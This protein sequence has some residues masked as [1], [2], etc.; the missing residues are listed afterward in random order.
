MAVYTDISDDDLTA[1]V[2][3]Y[4]IGEVLS[5]KGIA[6]GVENSN[7]LLVT[8]QG[9]FILTLYEK[10][11]DANDLPFFLGLTE[12]LSARG[13][14]CP[15]PVHAL[16]GEVLR[17][18]SGRP[19]AIVTFLTGMWPKRIQNHHCA[20]LGRAM[21]E[22]HVTG[23]D[24]ELSRP[25]ALSVESWRPLL[26][27]C[28]GRGDDVLP[29]ITAALN[30]ELDVL[31]SEWPRDLPSGVIH[32][33]LFPDNVFFR[34]E[35]LSG[36]IDFYFACN[37]Q[38]AYDLGICLN[39]WCF[40]RDGSFNATKARKMLRAYRK[41][42]ELSDAEVQA[43]PLLARGAAMRFLLTR[44][45][46]W[47]NTPENALVT[48]KNPLEYYDKLRFHQAVTGPGAYGLD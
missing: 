13:I 30:A 4:G 1:F 8:E 10:R 16:N 31:E 34:G 7:F 47:L 48:P 11:V 33:D 42:R 44:L 22:M 35:H 26:E 27:A 45:Y 15:T 40:E 37:D 12:H 19:A 39:A 25:N 28:E 18:L 6:E 9:S 46:D 5:C 2:A 32:A 24:F 36:L 41:V 43:L 20:E 23:A 3:G 17:E 21:A 29:G 38:F 14:P